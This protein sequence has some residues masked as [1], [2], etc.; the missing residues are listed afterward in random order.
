MDRQRP[1]DPP[2]EITAARANSPITRMT[3]P[4]GHEGWLVTSQHAVREIL[5][6]P[7]FSN[8]LEYIHSPIPSRS[9]ADLNFEI[10]PGMFNRMD[11]PDHT[12]IR[13]MLISQFTVRRMNLLEPRIAQIAEEHLDA[14]ERD[15]SPVDLVPAFTLPIPS[16]VICELLGVPYESRQRFQHDAAT[17]LNLEADP[18]DMGKAWFSLRDMLGEIIDAKRATPTDDLLGGLVVENELNQEELITVAMVLLIAG[19]ET[20]AN[21]LALGTYTLLQQPEQREALLNDP[22]N[23][24]EEL[25]RYLSIIHIGPARVAAEDV[26]IDGHLIKAGDTV[27]MSVPGANRDPEKFK[28]PDT[29]DVTRDAHGHVAFGHGI[30]QCLGQQLARI[31]MRIGFAALLRRFPTLRLDGDVRF[32]NKMSIYGVH[33]LLVVLC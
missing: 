13:R 7:K 15:G 18:A 17:M 5:A 26:E 32:R 20:T 2:D 19:H 16:L 28:N 25:L 6:S 23:A 22:A 33:N 11:P 3:F 24:V 9:L 8:D 29:V 27:V 30:H 10:P 31:E 12:R 14:I 21:M 4:D 1:L